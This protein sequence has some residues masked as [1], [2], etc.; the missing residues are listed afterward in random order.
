MRSPKKKRLRTERLKTLAV[1]VLAGAGTL[2][3]SAAAAALFASMTDLPQSVV[4]MLSSLALAA[5]C[6]ACAY[7]CAD[8]R[9]RDGLV[10]GLLW[11]I[12]ALTATLIAGAFTVKVFSAG[13]II[14]K[15]LIMLCASAIGGIKGVNASSFK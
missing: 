3:I 4:K 13:G 8:R 6:F 15:A 10:T 14:T 2:A 1:S 5:G 11:G 9:R 7:T 12:A